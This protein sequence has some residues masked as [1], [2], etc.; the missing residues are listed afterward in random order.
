MRTEKFD[1]RLRI[2]STLV[3]SFNSDDLFIIEYGDLLKDIRTDEDRQRRAQHAL[4]MRKLL[5]IQAEFLMNA[6]LRAKHDV[7]NVQ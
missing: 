1:E 7:V 4:R 5:M 6:W 3:G 2:L